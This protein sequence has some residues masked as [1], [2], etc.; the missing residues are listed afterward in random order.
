MFEWCM[1]H[2]YLTSIISIV[3]LV[4]FGNIFYYSSRAAIYIRKTQIIKLMIKKSMINIEETLK[5]LL[6]ED[7]NDK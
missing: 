1:G 2:P 6:E 5:S 3:A 7:E 4:T